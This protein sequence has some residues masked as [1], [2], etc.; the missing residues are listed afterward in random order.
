MVE[1]KP[2]GG[3]PLDGAVEPTSKR[4]V[5]GNPADVVYP[6]SHLVKASG[7]RELEPLAHHRDAGA[8]ADNQRGNEDSGR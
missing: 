7:V 4:R 2:V 8:S 3:R 1:P 6:R 5:G